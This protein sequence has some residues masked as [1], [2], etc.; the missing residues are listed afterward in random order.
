[1]VTKLFTMCAPD[2]AYFGQKDFQQTLVIKR[3]VR[4]LDMPV[5]IEVCPTARDHD[6]LALSSRNAYLSPP[7][8]ERALTLKRA[9][10]AAAGAVE[11]GAGREEALGVARTVFAAAGVAPEYVELLRAADLEAPRWEPGEEVVV[12]VAATIGRARLIDNAVLNVP[13]RLSDPLATAVT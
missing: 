6:G 8:R 13:S 10:D 5:R 1:V 12:A 7:E 4:D 11:R 2:V 9:L 3:L